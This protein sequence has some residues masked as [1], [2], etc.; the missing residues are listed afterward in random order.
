MECVYCVLKKED[1]MTFDEKKSDWFEYLR[2]LKALDHISQ[3]DLGV[4]LNER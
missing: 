4:I 1:C 2:S 3:R